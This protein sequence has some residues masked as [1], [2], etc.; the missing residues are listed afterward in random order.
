MAFARR[1]VDIQSI[2]NK[3]ELLTR[4]EAQLPALRILINGGKS[5]A[6]FVQG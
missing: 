2:P 4:K 3:I 6:E 1:A 5:L